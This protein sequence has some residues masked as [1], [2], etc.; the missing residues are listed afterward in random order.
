[1]CYF[2][3]LLT[4]FFCLSTTLV[5]SQIPLEIHIKDC[6]VE[7]TIGY[8]KFQ[9]YRKKRLINSFQTT[10]QRP[11]TLQLLKGGTYRIEY[12][13]FYRQQKS[14]FVNIREKKKYIVN[15]CLEYFDHSMVSLTPIINQLKEGEKYQIDFVDAQGV[16]YREQALIIRRRANQYFASFGE[17]EIELSAKQIEL[18]Q[19]F[20]IELSQMEPHDCTNT[21]TYTLTYNNTISKILD[22]SC[23]WEG[24]SFLIKD[25]GFEQ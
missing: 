1:M 16:V 23:W 14:V 10:S 25:L 13:T 7:H 22:A 4:S 19:H 15:L 24:G 3:W 8:F 21:D 9:V 5:L 2:S 6:R 12:E 18:V 20:E 17:K 11:K